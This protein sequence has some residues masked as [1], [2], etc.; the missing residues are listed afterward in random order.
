MFKDIS[1]PK[2]QPTPNLMPLV[3]SI[4][5]PIPTYPFTPILI[6]SPNWIPTVPEIIS[7]VPEIPAPIEA[8][9]F[10]VPNPK[11]IFGLAQWSSGN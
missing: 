3:K 11:Y 9:T 4:V 8:F 1:Y 7:A 5:N 2:P 6:A 10:H